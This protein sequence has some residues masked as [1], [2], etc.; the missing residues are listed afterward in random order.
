[1]LKIAMKIE[2]KIVE[3]QKSCRLKFI[4]LR[5]KFETKFL[6]RMPKNL[7]ETQTKLQIALKFVADT[8]YYYLVKECNRQCFTNERNFGEK[9]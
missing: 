3:I 4:M 9:C 8:I 6:C 1:M 7:N 5:K 2:L